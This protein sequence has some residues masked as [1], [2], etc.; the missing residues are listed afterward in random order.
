MIDFDIKKIL[1]IYYEDL[2]IYGNFD[3]E[4]WYIFEDL[5]KPP[6]FSMWQKEFFVRI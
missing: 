1:C 5:P 4:N 6:G 2:D 3:Y